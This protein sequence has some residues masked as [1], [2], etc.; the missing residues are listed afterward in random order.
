MSWTI[1]KTFCS[2]QELVP[3]K[4]MVVFD[5]LDS[6]DEGSLKLL[7]NVLR[8]TEKDWINPS[9]IIVTSNYAFSIDDNCHN[10]HLD[11]DWIPSSLNQ[12]SV[13]LL[14]TF[15]QNVL[16]DAFKKDRA[17][18]ETSRT[19]MDIFHRLHLLVTVKD[20]FIDIFNASLNLITLVGYLQCEDVKVE[21]FVLFLSKM[22]N[23]SSELCTKVLK[24]FG[25]RLL[26]IH[27]PRGDGPEYISLFS[28]H[29]FAEEF[30][31]PHKMVQFVCKIQF[32]YSEPEDNFT[33][34]TYAKFLKAWKELRLEDE[35]ELVEDDIYTELFPQLADALI[36]N[37]EYLEGNYFYEL[38][39]IVQDYGSDESVEIFFNRYTTL[40]STKHR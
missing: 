30:I 15:I 3:K 2:R 4:F 5:N 13:I 8:N 7:I 38:F 21:P 10:I 22:T 9:C 17:V 29:S 16:K 40:I 39:K 25:D 26:R 35:D 1:F 36:Q 11:Y 19:L 31:L 18:I 37:C 23:L 32:G 14:P 12:F 28:L 20:K 24:T 34:A 6:K 33:V 27:S